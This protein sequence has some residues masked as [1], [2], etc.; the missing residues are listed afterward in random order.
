MPKM[1]LTLI[2]SSPN[3]VIIYVDNPYKNFSVKRSGLDASPLL[4]NL[5]A[6][7]PEIGWYVMSPLLSTLKEDEF[8][9]VS[10][11]LERGEYDPNILDEGTDYVRLET[12]L[13]EAKRGGEAV[14]CATI[15][16]I[17]QVLELPGLQDL[18]IRKLKALATREPHHPFAILCVVESIFDQADKDLRQYLVQYLADHY[19][20]LVLAETVKMAEVMRGIGD[21]EKSVFRLL[22]GPVETDANMDADV[23]IKIEEDDA[24]VE[25]DAPFFSD[26]VA[27]QEKSNDERTLS[28]EG[29]LP[30]KE[31]KNVDKEV[32]KPSTTKPVTASASSTNNRKPTAPAS[33]TNPRKPTAPSPP[34]KYKKPTVADLTEDGKEGIPQTQAEMIRAALR[35]S[36]NQATERQSRSSR[37]TD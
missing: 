35:N 15:Y 9:P 1:Q 12:E 37:R 5:I 28:D 30:G 34:T 7:N 18:A 6:Y 20:D 4:Q 23:E 2:P 26:N 29:K 32:E 10:Q 22:A 33:S 25:V 24:K 36:E 27:T 14:R 19:W 11:Y 8:L 3:R 31:K 13:T 21:L 16:S 17:A